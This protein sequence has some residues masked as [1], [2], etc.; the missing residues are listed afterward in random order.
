MCIAALVLGRGLRRELV[1][2]I[3]QVL[4]VDASSCNCF[5][6]ALRTGP[7]VFMPVD[8]TEG[9]WRTADGFYSSSAFLSLTLFLPC[10]RLATDGCDAAYHRA[11]T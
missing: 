7:K 3:S 1:P 8:S 9:F 11:S 2:G 10:R 5:T 6:S 4:S